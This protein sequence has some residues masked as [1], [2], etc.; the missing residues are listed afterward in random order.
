MIMNLM[1]KGEYPAEVLKAVENNS[2]VEGFKSN[3]L[4]EFTE[5]EKATVIGY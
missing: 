2:K 3:R 5:E 4:P 1:T